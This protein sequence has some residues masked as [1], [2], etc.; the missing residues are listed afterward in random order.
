MKV[1]LGIIAL[2]VISFGSYK[3][4]ANSNDPSKY[5]VVMKFTSGNTLALSDKYQGYDNCVNSAEYKLHN[6]VSK[7]SGADIRCSNKKPT[8]K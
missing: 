4:Y 6:I 3:L 2:F 5:T 8:Y 7:E 1:T